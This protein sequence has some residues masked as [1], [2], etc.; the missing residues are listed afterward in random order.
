[1]N[2]AKIGVGLLA[3]VTIAVVAYVFVGQNIIPKTTDGETAEVTP[4]EMNPPGEEAP[5]VAILTQKTVATPLSLSVEGET[6]DEAAEAARARLA[7]GMLMRG[8]M[9]YLSGN[10][11]NSIRRTGRLQVVETTRIERVLREISGEVP[12]DDDVSFDRPAQPA[13]P[14][15][16]QGAVERALRNAMTALGFGPGGEGP[17][18]DGSGAAAADLANAAETLG[19]NY[20][21]VVYVTEPKYESFIRSIPDTNRHVHVLRA[22]PTISYRLFDGVTGTVILADV[23][24]QYQ[25]L[26]FVY[27]HGTVPTNSEISRE[28][29][30]LEQRI[31]KEIVTNIVDTV[32]PAQVSLT[33]P[34]D[35]DVIVIDRGARDGIQVGDEFEI[36]RSI[37]QAVGANNITIAEHARELVGRARVT[38]LQDTLSFITPIEGGPFVRQDYVEI[39]GSGYDLRRKQQRG[40]GSEG[41]VGA[42]A[43]QSPAPALGIDMRRANESG[44]PDNRPRVAVREVDVSYIDCSSCSAADPH[45]SLLPQALLNELQNEQRIVSLSRQDLEAMLQ[46]RNFSDNAAGRSIRAG[47][48]GMTGAHYVLTGEA[49]VAPRTRVSTQRVA[50]QEVESSRTTTLYVSGPFRNLDA[51][52]SQ[53]VKSASVDFTLPGGASQSNLQRASDRVAELVTADLMI[54]LCPLAVLKVVSNQQI[55]LSSGLQAGLKEGMRLQAFSVGQ[56]IQD[57][58]GGRSDS[59][60]LATGQLVV[61]DV[62]ADRATARFAGQPFDLKARDQLEVISGQRSGASSANVARKTS[63]TKSTQSVTSEPTTNADQDDF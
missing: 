21:L 41:G 6:E 49:T 11:A 39:F 59:G 42:A 26:E 33:D 60:R 10:L 45:K 63:Q 32:F 43:S 58:Y 50:G 24:Q 57:I 14:T 18:D 34:T 4:E 8:A 22:A 31:A 2:I 44:E 16:E 20:I 9:D 27:D 23:S 40:E 51:E 36:T 3:A 15:E 25:P 12:A 55:E 28:Y 52:T 54:K 5:L 56:E 29:V 17:I 62:R 47:L 53:L 13:M 35:P 38:R 1:M 7:A 19:A 30:A 46:E 48:E 61:T 37:G